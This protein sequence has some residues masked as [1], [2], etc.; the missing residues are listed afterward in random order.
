MCC[1]YLLLVA[2]DSSMEP[3]ALLACSTPPLLPLV[4]GMLLVLPCS[5]TQPPTH[6]HNQISCV[7]SLCHTKLPLTCSPR[8]T[9][10]PLWYPPTA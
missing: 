7:T 2:D 1:L 10:T 3:A 5:S 8:A 6:P 4:Y 9:Q